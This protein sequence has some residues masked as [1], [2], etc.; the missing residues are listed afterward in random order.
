MF[1]KILAIYLVL[2]VLN[3]SAGM[4]LYVFADRFV[5][6]GT[7]VLAGLAMLLCE[8][9][10]YL[11]PKWPICL[12]LFLVWHF[13]SRPFYPLTQHAIYNVFFALILFYLTTT[14][15]S[16]FRWTLWAIM[17]N[18]L[19]NIVWAGGQ[20]AGFDLIFQ[21]HGPAGFFIDQPSLAGYLALAA[22]LFAYYTTVWVGIALFCAFINNY[23]AIFANLAS[24]M[25]ICCRRT[26][27]WMATVSIIGITGFALI[28]QKSLLIKIA[29]RL[30]L[31]EKTLSAA[32]LAPLSGY[33][34]GRFVD[35]G[36]QIS[37]TGVNYFTAKS[38]PFEFMFEVGAVVGLGIIITI[39]ALLIRRYI[40]AQ[41]TWTLKVLSISLVSFFLMCCAQSHLRHPKI[42]P[43]V[44]VLLG[45][46]YILTETKK[47]EAHG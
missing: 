24:G 20:M 36:S 18:T 27:T 1:D 33:G 47:E 40:K 44:M 19:V 8:P 6:I 14:F 25:M 29:S 26:Y 32:F 39:L 46:F 21:G 38:E 12:F 28:H 35:F 11:I 9:K 41:K 43:T 37:K 17:I 5:M 31:W 23:T 3:Y 2:S 4:D 45:F 34:L 30:E 10:R 7:M 13:F 42:A 15:A 16:D 22:P